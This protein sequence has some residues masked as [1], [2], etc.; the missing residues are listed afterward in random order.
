MCCAPLPWPG[1]S[2]RSLDLQV[3][4]KKALHDKNVFSPHFLSHECRYSFTVLLCYLFYAL[5]KKLGLVCKCFLDATYEAVQD[6]CSPLER[7]SV[8]AISFR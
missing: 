2:I 6:L 4:I 3:L 1:C 7:A 5:T 8:Q